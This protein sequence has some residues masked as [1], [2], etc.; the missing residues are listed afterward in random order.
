MNDNDYKTTELTSKKIGKNIKASFNVG[1]HHCKCYKS[2]LNS[3]MYIF[4]I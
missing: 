4:N 2:K 1:I 3:S